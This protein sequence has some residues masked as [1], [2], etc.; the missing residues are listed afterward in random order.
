MAINENIVI[1]LMADTS[2]YATKMQAASAQAE[3]LAAAIEKPRT[4]SEKFGAA[5][6]KTGLAVG[7]LSAAIGVAAVKSFVDFDAK[8]SEV[9]ANTGATGSALNSLR[10]A[11][12]NAS[13]TSIYSAEDAADAINEL[14]KAGVSVTDILNGGLHAA[15]SLAATDGMSV[16]DATQYMASAMTQF[17]LTG[18]QAGQV[19]D[20][21]AAGANKALGSV[22]DMGQALSMVGSTSHMLGANMQETVG[23]L[24]AMANAGNIG[25]EAG[26]QL[27]SALIGLMSPSQAAS[28]EM[29]ALGLSLYD[30]QGKFV[31]IADFAGQ[32]HDKL[33]ALPEASRNQAMGILF[34]NAAM[35]AANT[36]YTEGEEGIKK[37]TDSVSESGYAADIAAKKTDNFKGDLTKFVHTAQDVLIGLGEAGNGPLRSVTQNA[38]N[39]L[40]LFRSMP[41]A[42]Q[43]WTVGIGLAV[44]AVAGL[45]KMFG[46]LQKSS[47]G[48][49]RTMS[50]VVDPVQRLQESGKGLVAMGQSLV[51]G[52]SSADKQ[53]QTFG[54][55]V[56]KTQAFS[57]AGKAGL[58]S[59]VDLLGGPWGIALSVAGIALG[60]FAAEQ[61]KTKQSTDS[62]ATALKNGESAVIELRKQLNS[63][64]YKLNFYDKWVTGIDSYSDAIKRAGISQSTY[65]AA[66]MGSKSANDTVN[67]ALKKLTKST[68]AN[69]SQAAANAKIASDNAAVVGTVSGGLSKMSKEYKNAQ[70][71]AKAEAEVTDQNTQKKMYNTAV[72]AGNTS[73]LKLNGRA[74]EE[75][76]SS[77]EILVSAFDA[78]TEGVNNTAAA[79]GNTI[80]ALKT[81]YGFTISASDA[82]IKLHDSFDKATKAV[83]DNGATL[84]INTAKGRDNQ[85]ALNDIAKSAKDAA[86]AHARAGDDMAK[87]GPILDDARNKYIAAA[88]AMG[89][90]P[91]EAAALADSVGLS[92][93]AVQELVDKIK[94]ANATPIEITDNASKVLDDLNVKAKALEDGKTITI[95]GDN[96]PYIDMVAKI[97]GTK[98]DPKTGELSLDKKQYDIALA[99]ANGA[100][101]DPKTG[102]MYGDNS[103]MWKKIADANKWTIDPKTG[104]IFGDDGPFTTVKQKIDATYINGK[105]VTITGDA[106]NFWAEMGKITGYRPPQ[107]S[108]GIGAYTVKGLLDHMDGHADGGYISGPGTG[109]SDSVPAMLSNGEYVMTAEAV[110]RLGIGNLDKLNYQ[111]YADGGFVQKY[112]AAHL[113][114]YLPNAMTKSDLPMNVNFYGD[115][116]LDSRA[117]TEFEVQKVG[118][119]VGAA[120]RSRR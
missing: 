32:L 96:K 71:Q 48:F 74:S 19:A 72:L 37:W 65:I 15:L 28:N 41:A 109:T 115:M 76:A 70:E 8:M 79:L 98:I 63:D 35:S 101:I 58:G 103:E 49:N 111:R 73:E 66:A 119:R 31:G 30:S 55:T 23:T 11:A 40:N 3:H 61:Q 62:L 97:T 14:A 54:T 46:D 64:D 21:L 59:I 45:H 117:A 69:S 16:G 36:L 84:D 105:S 42:A 108:V 120:I 18:K 92:S 25:S 113:H 80:D 7:A 20:A 67:D 39:L 114:D 50:L 29:K 118:F 95:K 112:A 52:F 91:E 82:D 99:L 43:Q 17:G 44:G 104:Q 86:E 68:A 107:T 22:S 10:E 77:K 81:Y 106:S 51:A 78:T 93:G 110:G 13:R 53:Y 34:S 5:A 12:L 57:A 83:E 90:T 1:R 60:L 38:T 88:E 9:Q 100:R 75:V 26:T 56:S 116:R 6:M 47:S 94:Q 87:I 27:R 102:F 24:A 85:T 4:T 2:N 89:K 33:S